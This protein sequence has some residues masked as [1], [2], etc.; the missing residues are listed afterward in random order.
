MKITKKT[1]ADIEKDRGREPSNTSGA[2][3][4]EMAI[5]I[6]NPTPVSTNKL[7]LPEVIGIPNRDLYNH[8][9]IGIPAFTGVM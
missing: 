5:P 2:P 1:V 7:A 6:I 8:S 4:I 9:R 3:N